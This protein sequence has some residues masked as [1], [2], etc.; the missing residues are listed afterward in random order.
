MN[1]ILLFGSPNVGKTSIFN[2]LTNSKEKI[3]NFEGATVVRKS[4]K[5]LNTNINLVDLPGVDSISGDTVV[6]EVVFNELINSEMIISVIDATNFK[7]NSYMLIEILELNKPVNIVINMM[8]L[9]KGKMDISQIADVYNAHIQ[10][11]TKNKLDI[12]KELLIIPRNNEFLLDYG[13]D[14]ELAIDKISHLIQE[15]DTKRFIAIQFLKGNQLANDHITDLEAATAIRAHLSQV[16]SATSIVGHVFNTRRIFINELMQRTCEVEKVDNE[17]AFLNNH[18]DKIALHKFWGFVTFIAIM[19][20]VFF[21]TFN[22]TFIQ[23]IVDSILLRFSNFVETFLINSGASDLTL[24]FVI[25][26]VIAGV[27]GAITFIPQMLILFS[28]LAILEGVGYFS[29]VTALFEDLFNKLGL[30]SHSLI[31]YIT[32]F[33]CNVLS[34]LATRTIKSEPKRIATILTSPFVSCAAR[35][36]VYII[37]TDIFFTDNKALVLLFLHF[38][39]IFVAIIISYIIDKKIYK[40]PNL[41]SI[42]ALPRYKMI[43]PKYFFRLV[44][45]KL[46]SFIKRATKFILIGSIILWFLTHL[47][48][49]G[50]TMDVTQS[51]L[52]PICDKLSFIFTPIGITSVAVI[53]SLFGAFL[54]KE[55]AVTSLIV[56]YGAAS[57][58]ELAPMLQEDFTEASALAYLVFVLLYIPCLSTLA[59]IKA[60]TGSYKFVF[61]SVTMSIAVGYLLAFV[62]YHIALILL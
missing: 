29:R 46:K 39:G 13:N 54:A 8:D 7:R 16:I 18:F 47:S 14:M 23:A 9:Y 35:L 50:L 49:N 30:S 19:W 26:G 5:I 11:S 52:Y 21:I 12:D 27:T 43:E 22:V 15:C 10:V 3:S 17:L 40:E 62:T 51:I 38:L 59:A 57:V 25:D 53:V 45:A 56:S 42:H 34:I 61:Y 48:I 58:S 6:E 44:Y 2:T 4:A 36:P 33:G 55:L 24:S 20:V 31:P 60:E 41:I 1:D 37:F 28:L 32:G